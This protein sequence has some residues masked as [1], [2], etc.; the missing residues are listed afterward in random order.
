MQAHR[1]LTRAG[2]ALDADRGVQVGADEIVLVR[3]DRRHDVTHRPDARAL[4]LRPQQVGGEPEGLAEIEM[5]ILERG[6][7]PGVEAEA[8][9]QPN[10]HPLGRCGP[11]EATRDRRT[12]VDDDRIAV[13][14]ADVAPPDVQD[15]DTRCHDAGNRVAVAVDAPE[16]RGR[17]RV[18]TQRSEPLGAQSAQR[19]AGKFVDP[20]VGD[21]RGAGRHL[22]QA[23]ARDLEV[24]AFGEQ[25]RIIRHD[26]QTLRAPGN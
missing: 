3:L 8:P 14:V 15:L 26:E 1:G 21:G 9:P 6:E 12:P 25:L 20:V 24:V 17:V 16:E 19:L 18:G 10:A 23:A 22:G 2:G 5:L 7:R 11:I 4:D 13:R